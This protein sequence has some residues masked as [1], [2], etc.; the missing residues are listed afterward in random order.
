MGLPVV[1]TH[2][3]DPR[4]CGLGWC[5]CLFGDKLAPLI[6]AEPGKKLNYIYVDTY[7]Y[8]KDVG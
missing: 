4:A 6:I 1:N 2:T 7:S 5:S 3:L 8:S